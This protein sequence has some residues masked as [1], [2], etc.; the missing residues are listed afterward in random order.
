MLIGE[1]A[2]KCNT[3]KKAVQCYV[4]QELIIPKVLENGYKDFSERDVEVLRE[5]VLFRK[6]GL[7]ISEI[8]GLIKNSDEIASIL[9]RKTLELECQKMKQEILKKIES[10]ENIQ[11]LE[12]EIND[13]NSKTIIINRLME[14]F[15]NYYGKLIG[16]NFSRY[17]TGTIETEEQMQAFNQIIEFFDSVP[18]ID[19]PK[20]LQQY[21]EEYPFEEDMEKMKTIF[22]ERDHAF[23]NIEEF[24][25][26]N[27]EILDKYNEYKQ[28]EEFKNSAAFGLM[29]Y[30]KQICSAN[31]YYDV[32]IPAMR[33]LS[34]L[35]N[36]YYEQM[37]AAN[38]KFIKNYPEWKS[39]YESEKP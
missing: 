6:L 24:V 36:E 30:M 23:E 15:P 22:D 31:G 17:L 10:G 2:E 8:K 1:L 38:E 32:F 13:I 34:P 16:I 12:K 11:K 35:Y 21:L 4:E 20:D 26:N 5:I 9:Y 25:N 28:S 27:K 14:L 19:I 7:S 3:T 18:T 37:L 39:S 29:E 33:K